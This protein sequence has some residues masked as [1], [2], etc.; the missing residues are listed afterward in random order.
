MPK[1]VRSPHRALG[2][3]CALC[4]FGLPSCQGGPVF[5]NTGTLDAGLVSA[6]ISGASDAPMLALGARL[7]A[8]APAVDVLYLEGVQMALAT[9]GGV[10]QEF[11]PFVEFDTEDNQLL[12]RCSPDAG[13]E[14]SV[15]LIGLASGDGFRVEVE[16]RVAGRSD[17]LELSL[18]YRIADS[19]PADE[20]WLPLPDAEENSVAGDTAWHVP[21]AY[22][23]T[24]S[25][26]AAIAPDVDLL[27]EDRRLPQALARS[28][29]DRTLRHGLIA[30]REVRGQDGSLRHDTA[31]ATPVT[32]QGETL[33]FAHNLR[34]LAGAAP[35]QGLLAC[36][37]QLWREDARWLLQHSVLPLE[38]RV[39]RQA[40]LVLGRAVRDRLARMEGAMGA[41]ATLRSGRAGATHGHSGAD[42]WF[43][44][45]R[46]ILHTARGLTLAAPENTQLAREIVDLLLSAPRSNGLFPAVASFD[47]ATGN[48]RVSAEAKGPHDR[49][50]FQSTA[51][52]GRTAFELLQLA[53]RLPERRDAI[54][55][56]CRRTA[57]FLIA[58]QRAS[59]VIPGWF[60]LNYGAPAPGSETEPPF[61]AA[62]AALFLAAY[63][64]QTGS[65][66]A[67]AAARRYLDGLERIGVGSARLSVPGPSATAKG[68]G[69]GAASAGAAPAMSTGSGTASTTIDSLSLSFAA[70]AMVHLAKASGA[71]AD[72]ARATALLD[73]LSPYQNCNPRWDLPVSGRPGAFALTMTSPVRDGPHT[74]LIAE[75]L[76]EGYSVSGA[77]RHL[78]RGVL[79]L[80]SAQHGARDGDTDPAW[81]PA[82]GATAALQALETWGDAVVD[83]AGGFGVGIE[84]VWLEQV[85]A[86]DG[87]IALRPVSTLPPAAAV[88][89]TF[90]R[91]PTSSL[92]WTVSCGK[93]VIADVDRATLQAGLEIPVEAV[94]DLDF[95]P[96]HS[97]N[98]SRPWSPRARV[99]G[100]R[101][102]D[103]SWMEIRDPRG[104]VVRLPMAPPDGRG[105]AVAATP[106]MPVDLA[107]GQALQVRL[108]FRTTNGIR[109]APAREWATV[110]LGQATCLDTGDDMEWTLADAG[111]SRVVRFFD[112]RENARELGR[113]PL[114]YHVPVP[115]DATRVQLEAVVTGA[116][117]I[118]TMGQALHEDTVNSPSIRRIALDL[119]DRRLWRDGILPVTFENAGASG[120][121]AALARIEYRTTGASAVANAAPRERGA[122][123]AA[124]LRVLVVPIAMPDAPLKRSPEV[125]EQVFF[126][127]AAYRVTP[128][129]NSERTAGSVAE[130][131][132]RLSGGR[133]SCDGLVRSTLTIPELAAELANRSDG[134]MADLAAHLLGLDEMIQPDWDLVVVVHG[135]SP[136]LRA[137]EGK[138][139][140]A[141]PGRPAVVFLPDNLEKGS[142]LGSGT[143][144]GAMLRAAHDLPTL[145][146][147]DGGAFGHLALTA[148]GG[149][150]VPVGLLGEN[151]A[152]IGWADAIRQPAADATLTIP[153][154]YADRAFV[155]LPTYGLVGRGALHVEE[156]ANSVA[157]PGLTG[158]GT[159]IYWRRPDNN[160]PLLV[161]AD[162]RRA[163]PQRL[164]LSPQRPL[165][166]TPFE[167]GDEALDLFREPITL[168]GDARP[169][170]ATP[171]GDDLWHIKG[172]HSGEDGRSCAIEFRGRSLIDGLW[173]WSNGATPLR[174]SEGRRERGGVYSQ[175]SG[176]GFAPSVLPGAT[177][178]GVLEQA[179]PEAPHRLVGSF[180]LGERTGAVRVRAGI[181]ADVLFDITVDT[182][183]SAVPFEFDLPSAAK[184][185]LWLEVVDTD[186]ASINSVFLDALMLVPRQTVLD[187]IT[188]AQILPPLVPAVDG[189]WRSA[190]AE[191]AIMTDG[192]ATWRGPLV[193][194]KGARTLRLLAHRLRRGPIDGA[195]LTLTLRGT[196]A[197]FVAR[198]LDRE[199]M[200]GLEGSPGIVLLAELP[201]NT[202]DVLF[203]EIAVTGPT[204]A[205]I[206]IQALEI[207]R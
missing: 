65:E 32:V 192:L 99:R 22:S 83:V 78:E 12:A 89:V 137:I 136:A 95:R 35:T 62:S 189:A 159:L 173:S 163:R 7:A 109:Y 114:T 50:G 52:V 178:R 106:Y 69:S 16:D 190:V 18:R 149:G 27:A 98:G 30:Y 120:Q 94:A 100:W 55:D 57:S 174:R 205:A 63:A 171:E 61:E 101:E 152:R 202:P 175:G 36:V 5:R 38:D 8:A 191:L 108:A 125:L 143:A 155:V 164:R 144:M 154:L 46:Q 207:L 200:R 26:A 84:S 199:P 15:R 142:I 128:E 158:E 74:A 60:D 201:E 19:R 24:G 139:L 43:T 85:S 146:G 93:D 127:D 86:S 17:L 179:L 162:G 148:D 198:I 183:G 3:A 130:L 195:T 111:D 72:V 39:G 124:S 49:P 184:G 105:V 10:S 204:G 64:R 187:R 185:R 194:P 76:L 33:R 151:L 1:T 97:I 103:E 4:A 196:D 58:N 13:H 87:R 53:D 123:P 193:A 167:P 14:V 102:G 134:G 23:R 25:S 51:N 182:I 82:T 107:P 41:V 135:R 160:A 21:L 73:A 77:L 45:D 28:S 56:A 71:D 31:G 96:P 141:V 186:P 81:G 197:A 110:T 11:L 140:R 132:T 153:N 104:N 133:T 168:D 165:M 188:P 68:L 145:A 34:L 172:L 147:A 150:H 66:S 2:L 67:Q 180:L 121:P 44:V 115:R 80:R 70:R 169:S 116:L 37:D 42:A 88:R 29:K 54:L 166:V 129:P 206:G 75:A 79:A 157:E 126:G 40:R 112:G 138:A 91:V 20:Q 161:R 90:Q 47:P 59:G 122:A 9:G 48:R 6:T 181:G 170:L 92:A 118:S 177:I 117:R 119:A 156:R 176:I 203:A 131:I 113:G